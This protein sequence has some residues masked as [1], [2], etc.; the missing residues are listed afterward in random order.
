[1]NKGISWILPK[2]VGHANALDLL[3]SARKIEAHEAKAM[4]L[5]NKVFSKD[6]FIEEVNEYANEL[7]QLSSPRS[8][9]IM[10]KQVYSAMMQ[11]LEQSVL[12]GNSEMPASFESD[13]FKEGVAHF[14]E[15]RKPKFTGE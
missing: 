15:K 9:R 14:I 3:L 10:K 2:L 8:V 1:M 11:P 13:D 7:A 6:H 12:V 5:V 4:G